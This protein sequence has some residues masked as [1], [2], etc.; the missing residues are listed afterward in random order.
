MSPV[1]RGWRCI[2]DVGADMI[3]TPDRTFVTASTTRMKLGSGNMG[4][5]KHSAGRGEKHV[6]V[7]CESPSYRVVAEVDVVVVL[8]LECGFCRSPV[9]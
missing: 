9:S 4:N 3:L 1:V 6:A 5:L 2:S 7:L 8:N